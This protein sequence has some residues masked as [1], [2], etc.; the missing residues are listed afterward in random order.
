MLNKRFGLFHDTSGET[1]SVRLCIYKI[2]SNSKIPYL[3]FLLKN[4]QDKYAFVEYSYT[5]PDS[6]DPH[7][8]FINVLNQQINELTKPSIKGGDDSSVATNPPQENT[9]VSSEMDVNSPPP[10]NVLPQ[11]QIEQ[12]IVDQP[13]VLPE[14]EQP[15]VDQPNVLPEQEQPI[16]D[17]T[18]LLP[19]QEQIEQPN[20][21]PEQEQI[22]QPNVLP[23][24]E[25]I[26]QPNVLPEQEQIDQHIV[27]QTAI[28]PE[29]EQIEQPIVDQPNVLP[30]ETSFF[31][32][33][34]PPQEQPTE[35]Q[36]TS[37][38]FGEQPPPQEQPIEGQ[39][40]SSFF[41]EQQPPPPQEQQIE[42]QETSSFFG[43]Q[44]TE[45][46]E[47]SSFFGENVE[48]P[49]SG[50]SIDPPTFKGIIPYYSEKNV[51]VILNF[52]KTEFEESN[53]YK[54]A[55][56]DEIKNIQ[57]INNVPIDSE[58]KYFLDENEYMKVIHNEY[59][60]PVPIPKV[61]YLC[62]EDENGQ[63]VNV[64]KN[65]FNKVL[66]PRTYINGKGN[67]FLFSETPIVKNEERVLQQ[68]LIFYEEPEK[69]V[70]KDPFF[71][72][73]YQKFEDKYL[74]NSFIKQNTQYL[75]VKSLEYICEK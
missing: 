28:L 19:E 75:F 23:E 6:E 49:F 18:A 14:Q 60:R 30:Q 63:I 33:Q 62:K 10:E 21:L 43:E 36:E 24:Q 52:T 40:A 55:T 56:L 46:Q 8:D 29:E 26:E 20:V 5:S 16:V 72:F 31:G 38:F 68:F 7:D 13:N 66:I 27:D 65:S 1:Y 4:K 69:T 58:I 48:S 2:N 74:F 71:S 37:S 12:P 32:E 22:E 25:Q 61:M 53:T 44:P 41:G 15:I 67:Y 57:Q 42:G 59:L 3:N 35:G 34:P 45:G 73:F 39:E 54:W 70:L 64:E 51:Y 11:E 17:Q 50:E 9:N 47:T